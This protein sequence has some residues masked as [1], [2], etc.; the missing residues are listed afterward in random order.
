ARRAE[1]VGQQVARLGAADREALRTALP[2]LRA[3]AV[4]LQQ[5][6]GA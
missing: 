1:L 2:A 3:L 6:P 4:G 5:E